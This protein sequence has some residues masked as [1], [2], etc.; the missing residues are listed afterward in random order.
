MY[1][2]NKNKKITAPLIQRF[3]YI[4]YELLLAIPLAFSTGMWMNLATS[5]PFEEYPVR[6]VIPPE[7]IGELPNGHY[8][9]DMDIDVV[10]TPKKLLIKPKIETKVISYI[11]PQLPANDHK[12]FDITTNN[13]ILSNNDGQLMLKPLDNGPIEMQF[14]TE[15]V[16]KALIITI[17]S[18]GMVIGFMLTQVAV[19]RK[20]KKRI[21]LND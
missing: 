16:W 3:P 19:N 4:K 5:V 8:L 6:K 10:V 15:G 18:W 17:V 11:L 21:R 13:A 7:I 1:L 2:L 9:S 20:K 14:C 12:L